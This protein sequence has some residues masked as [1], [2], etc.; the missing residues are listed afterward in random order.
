MQATQKKI[1]LFATLRDIAKTRELTVEIRDGQ[2]VAELIDS[3]REQKPELAAEIVNEDGELTGLVHILVHG[4]HIQWLD[5]LDTKIRT[6]DILVLMP[7][8]AGG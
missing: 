7:P 3:I 5:G 1:K 2:T 6:S 4:R 8:S